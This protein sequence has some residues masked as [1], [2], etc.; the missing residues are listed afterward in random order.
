MTLDD[1]K[2]QLQT[3]LCST[4]KTFKLG[5]QRM[6]AIL[7]LLL[8]APAGSRPDSIIRLRFQDMRIVLRRD[9]VDPVNG[10]RRLLIRLT[11]K[12][13]KRYLGKK[14]EKTFAANDVKNVQ[15]LVGDALER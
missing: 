14:A 13:T 1:L 15:V 11:L 8:L 7:F 9:P 4:E 12:F 5:E 2:I 3:T 10:P 6:L